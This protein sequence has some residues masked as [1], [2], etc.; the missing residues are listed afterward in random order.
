VTSYKNEFDRRAVAIA[1][2]SFSEPA[3]LSSYQDHHS[4]PFPIL[5]DPDRT[6]YQAFGL[7]KLSL[8][9]VFSP[10]TMR[11]YFKL[12]LEGMRPRNYGKDDFYQSGGDFLIDHRGDVLFAHRSRDP[13]DR[14][15]AAKLLEEID[16]VQPAAGR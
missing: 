3:K 6:A 16:R 5:A 7:R 12:F 15:T 9:R 11:L 14:P 13:A 8:L 1:I 4:W 10:S 2:V